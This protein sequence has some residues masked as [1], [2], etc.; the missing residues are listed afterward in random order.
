MTHNI[1]ES[2][3]KDEAS[4]ILY[5]LDMIIEEVYQRNA[6]LKKLAAKN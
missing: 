3:T 1:Y 2:V 5:F 6:R 4:Y